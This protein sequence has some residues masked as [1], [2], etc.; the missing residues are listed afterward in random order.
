MKTIY[1]A[2]DNNDN[3]ETFT[4]FSAWTESY[5]QFMEVKQ[6]NKKKLTRLRILFKFNQAI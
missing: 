4:C 3:I 2:K 5:V 1:T 6:W